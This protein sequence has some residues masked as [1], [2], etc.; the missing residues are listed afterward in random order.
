M[1]NDVESEP[2]VNM[3]IRNSKMP[4]INITVTYLICLDSIMITSHQPIMNFILNYLISTLL[5]I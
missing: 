4:D 3:L 2:E 5:E 1:D